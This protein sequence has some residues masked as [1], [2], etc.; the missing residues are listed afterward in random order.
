[1]VRACII[2]L[3]A[4]L[5]GCGADTMSSAATAAALKKQEAEQG[6]KTLT[7]FRQRIDAAAEEMQ[8]S[9]AKTAAAA[10]GD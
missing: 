3:V 5:T 8:R 9:A 7:E 10:N 4:L 2:L 6:K 1:M